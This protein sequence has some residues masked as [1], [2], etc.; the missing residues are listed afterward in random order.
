M[1]LA[2]RSR[3]PAPRTFAIV[4]RIEALI[5]PARADAIDQ[6]S[7]LLDQFKGESGTTAQAI[8]DFLLDLMTLVVVVENTPKRLYNPARQ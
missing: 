2:M 4:K 6:A 7:V 5:T 3:G 1:N 8:D